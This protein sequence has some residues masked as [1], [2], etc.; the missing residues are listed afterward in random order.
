MTDSVAHDRLREICDA[1]VH[2]P[3]DPHLFEHRVVDLARLKERTADS[4]L[5]LAARIVADADRTA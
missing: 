5:D 1:I 3:F 2:V 4:C